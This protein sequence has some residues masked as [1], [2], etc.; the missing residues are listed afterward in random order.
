MFPDDFAYTSGGNANAVPKCSSPELDSDSLS[1]RETPDGGD[2]VDF[3]LVKYVKWNVPS[4][5]AAVTE[6]E[7]QL[8]IRR[9]VAREILPDNET[10]RLKKS[11]GPSH[12]RRHSRKASFEIG[13][14][15]DEAPIPTSDSELDEKTKAQASSRCST[16]SVE[17]SSEKP[18]TEH[19][20]LSELYRES[21]LDELD[22]TSSIDQERGRIPYERQTM[23]HGAGDQAPLMARHKIS[24]I[25]EA[26]HARSAR[27]STDVTALKILSRGG[28]NGRTGAY[29]DPKAFGDGRG[30]TVSP[31]PSASQLR[32]ARAAR[33]SSDSD[34]E[35]V[36]S[37][38]MFESGYSDM[39]PIGQS[40]LVVDCWARDAAENPCSTC[41]E[42]EPRFKWLRRSVAPFTAIAGAFLVSLASM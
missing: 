14:A 38:S 15:V 24:D 41:E 6:I 9:A 32:A 29:N 22:D 42:I 26:V 19:L 7:G 20:V 27:S 37:I 4:A 11:M 23:R 16:F 17:T 12:K 30:F 13:S 36:D 31:L 3:R 10:M 8:P 25:T 35:T 39:I 21:Y 18:D 28:L 33:H 2:Q 40:G 1:A 34:S 5:D